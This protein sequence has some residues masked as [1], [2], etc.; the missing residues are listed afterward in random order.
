MCDMIARWHRQGFG[1]QLSY[2]QTVFGISVLMKITVKYRNR[3]RRKRFNPSGAEI[4][5]MIHRSIQ[6]KMAADAVA[7]ISITMVLTM[8]DKRVF[9][10][11]EDGFHLPGSHRQW[12]IG[13]EDMI[14][15]HPVWV[16]VMSTG[17]YSFQGCYDILLLKDW[18]TAAQYKQV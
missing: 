18:S 4:E 12:I 15:C 6:S 7:K 13:N 11:K 5:Y 3:I 17:W 14:L 1:H 2:G 10:L 8:H 16:N 9:V